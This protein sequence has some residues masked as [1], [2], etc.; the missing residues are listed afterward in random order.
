VDKLVYTV[1]FA[2]RLEETLLMETMLPVINSIATTV[3]KFKDG[4]ENQILNFC[5]ISFYLLCVWHTN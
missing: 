3:S 5:L 2:L 4:K 1:L